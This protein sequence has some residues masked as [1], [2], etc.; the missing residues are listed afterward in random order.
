MDALEEEYT[1]QLF[2]NQMTEFQENTGEKIIKL[3]DEEQYILEVNVLGLIATARAITLKYGENDEANNAL[4][5]TAIFMLK[6][7]KKPTEPSS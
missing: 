3:L 6:N 5:D 4:L 7:A 1:R 2:V